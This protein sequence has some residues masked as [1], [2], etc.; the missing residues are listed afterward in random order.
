MRSHGAAEYPTSLWRKRRIMPGFH[1]PV[2]AAIGAAVFSVSL[3]A[4]GAAVHTVTPVSLAADIHVAEPTD[5]VPGDQDTNVQ[6]VSANTASEDAIASALKA[7]G[8]SSP[9]RWAAE[10]VEYRPYSTDDLGLAKLRENLAKYNPAAAT[11]DQILSVL[12]P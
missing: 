2:L 10:V 6:K 5:P 8:V 4:G 7:A 3:A 11:V 12:L 1:R 9:K